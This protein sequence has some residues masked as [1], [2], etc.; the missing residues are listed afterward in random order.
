MYYHEF[1]DISQEIYPFKIIVHDDN[2]SQVQIE[3]HWHRSFEISYTSKGSI[4]N[5]MIEDE[6]FQTKA[7]DL[8]FINSNQVHGIDSR[9]NNDENQ[10]SNLALSLLFPYEFMEK[11][12]PDYHSRWY[13][14]PGKQLLTPTQVQALA[15]CQGLLEEILHEVCHHSSYSKLIVMKSVYQFLFEITQAFSEIREETHEVKQSYADLRKVNEIIFYIEQH[16]N[17]ELSL[18]R[19]SQEFHF[20]EGHFSRFFK[21]YMGTSVMNY[22]NTFRMN[23]AK[24][25]LLKTD[26]P[27]D[28]ISD[29]IGFGSSKSLTRLFKKYEEL[30][31]AQ[32]RK[33][34]RGRK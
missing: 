29:Q 27:I 19:F 21:R 23:Q 28:V 24:R 1:I 3:N 22:V 30:T 7:G 13:H 8:L 15:T 2:H 16:Y 26:L 11:E 25:L 18:E 14:Q 4:P 6:T 12:V 32:F 20:S 9:S 10:Q 5:F 33:Q 17:E 34:V 31:P